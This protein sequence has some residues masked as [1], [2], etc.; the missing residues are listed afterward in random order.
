MS[1][2]SLRLWCAETPHYFNITPP[3]VIIIWTKQNQNVSPRWLLGNDLSWFRTETWAV[4]RPSVNCIFVFW[5]VLPC[6]II[7]DLRFRGMYLWNVGRQLFYTAL[8]PRRQIWTSYSP[9]WELEVCDVVR[10]RRKFEKHCIRPSDLAGYHQ[11]SY[12]TSR[13][14]QNWL[15]IENIAVHR[16]SIWWSYCMGQSSGLPIQQSISQGDNVSR[17]VLY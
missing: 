8:H 11:R 14:V 13:K 15:L 7:F 1:L 10:D 12:C 3:T 17:C 4:I 6:K 2:I 16:T 9:P 5:D